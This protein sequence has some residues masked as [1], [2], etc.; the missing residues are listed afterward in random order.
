MEEYIEKMREDVIVE[1]KENVRIVMK[2]EYKYDNSGRK[3][4]MYWLYLAR[5][6]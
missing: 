5:F 2:M 4:D 6:V 3:I 1:I